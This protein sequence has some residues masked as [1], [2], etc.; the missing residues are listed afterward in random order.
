MSQKIVDDF[1]CKYCNYYTSRKFDFDKHNLTPKHKNRTLLEQK[2]SN[3]CNLGNNI[4]IKNTYTNSNNGNNG[5]NKNYICDCGKQ[6]KARNSLW[7]HKQSCKFNKTD[8]G[9][10]NNK[11]DINQLC[12]ALNEERK[13]N[14]KITEENTHLVNTII[15]QS[16]SIIKLADKPRTVNNMTVNMY[17]NEKC[18]NAMNIRDF[19]QNLT[20]TMEQLMYTKEHGLAK[21]ITNILIEN[22]KDIDQTERPIHCTDSKRHSLQIKDEIWKSD[23]EDPKI[24]E[25]FVTGMSNIHLE[26]YINGQMIIQDG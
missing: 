5:N 16:E 15:N 7:Y 8:M 17:L 6:Y 20:V 11:N 26:L 10:D 13:A 9:N 24:V 14:V 2:V 25:E 4:D 12:K 22:F 18:G 23:K 3:N 19:V 21:G 1:I